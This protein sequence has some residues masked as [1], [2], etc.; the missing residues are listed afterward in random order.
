MRVENIKGAVWTIDDE[1]YYKRRPRRGVAS[2]V[3]PRSN[4]SIGQP[5]TL[6]PQTPSTIDQ[7]GGIF[8]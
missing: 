6:T 4:Q 8:Q 1:E 7:V 5:S 3:L 2:T